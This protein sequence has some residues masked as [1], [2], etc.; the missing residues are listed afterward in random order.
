MYCLS[1]AGRDL[2]PAPIEL[3]CKSDSG[4]LAFTVD[5]L[6]SPEECSRLIAS[7]DQRGYSPALVNVGGGRQMAIPDVRKS[8]RC[9]IDDQEMAEHLWAR[10]KPQLPIAYTQ[11]GISIGRKR[12]R[13]VGLNERFRFL[14]YEPGDYFAPHRDGSFRRPRISDEHPEM[15]FL[16]AMF[17]LNAPGRGGETRF[18]DSRDESRGVDVRPTEGLCLIF[19]HNIYHEGCLLERGVKYAIRTDVMFAVVPDGTCA[20]EEIKRDGA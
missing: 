11:S 3:P 4:K 16:T 17:Y 7:S 6:L 1:T 10:L 18:V 8:G 13:A 2:S 5:G 15:S 9:I 20:P 12:W 14:K 19:D